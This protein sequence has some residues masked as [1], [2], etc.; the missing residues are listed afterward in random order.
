MWVGEGGGK[1]GVPKQRLSVAEGW[2]GNGNTATAGWLRAHVDIGTHITAV[3]G[4]TLTKIRPFLLHVLPQLPT[5]Q[6]GTGLPVHRQREWQLLGLH[7]SR[8]W[9]YPQRPEPAADAR[10][11]PADRREKNVLQGTNCTAYRIVRP[12]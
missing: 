11:R 3:Q 5:Q 6:L 10:V 2:C 7:L 4:L 12:G 1:R 9:T 8:F